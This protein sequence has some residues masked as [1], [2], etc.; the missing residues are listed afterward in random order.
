MV[1]FFILV[2][3]TLAIILTNRYRSLNRVP[4]IDVLHA[5]SEEVIVDFRDYNDV[6]NKKVSE[7]IVIPIAYLKRYY[8]EIPSKQVHVVASTKLEKN[9][10]IRFLQKNGFHVS[11]YTLSEC[12]CQNK[13]NLI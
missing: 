7:A 13:E 12:M 11:G 1:Y 5:S 8:H 3:L 6:T 2:L 9:I 4:C 10:G